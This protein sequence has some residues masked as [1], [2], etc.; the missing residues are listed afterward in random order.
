MLTWACGLRN[1]GRNSGE[2]SSTQLIDGDGTF[3][4]GG[5]ENFIKEVKLREC[6]HSY[7]VVS[8]MG[9]HISGSTLL[10][11]LFGTNFSEMDHLKGRS[12]TTKGIW[13]ATAAGME[14]CT[15]VMDLEGT[16]EGED[17][18]AF[19]KQSALFALAVSD[20]VLINM[21]CQNIGREKAASKPLL[22]TAFQVMMRLFN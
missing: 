12:Q 15:P 10:N 1:I 21:W 16:G 22:K 8:T 19:E 3:N 13:M 14:P 18:T 5:L 4:V 7:A 20:I 2:C 9:P 17:S 11:H 6:G